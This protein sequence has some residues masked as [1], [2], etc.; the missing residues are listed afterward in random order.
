MQVHEIISQKTLPLV[1]VSIEKVQTSGF[2]P[3]LHSKRLDMLKNGDRSMAGTADDAKI[4]S[5]IDLAYNK[6]VK[7]YPKVESAGSF[8][9]ID[10]ETNKPFKQE[11]YMV[12]LNL[13]DT[14]SDVKFFTSEKAAK[15]FAKSGGKIGGRIDVGNA[16]GKNAYNNTSLR[17]ALAV[18]DVDFDTGKKGLGL[19]RSGSSKVGKMPEDTKA[20]LIE[21]AEEHTKK[22]RKNYKKSYTK[23]Q[24]RYYRKLVHY[25]QNGKML[26]SIRTVGVL[27]AIVV[28]FDEFYEGLSKAIGTAIDNDEDITAAI[29]RYIKQMLP[30]M[31]GDIAAFWGA[32][33]IGG[34]AVRA[35]VRGLLTAFRPFFV[36]LG[37]PAGVAFSVLATIAG[38]VGLWVLLSTDFGQKYLMGMTRG[39]TDIAISTLMND[40]S[41]LT[42]GYTS[43]NEFQ[44]YTS[45]VIN[46]TISEEPIEASK[47]EL[48]A[49]AKELDKENG[50]EKTYSI[51]DLDFN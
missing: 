39:I 1:E 40:V 7:F 37:G 10:R 14:P 25:L 46:S 9:F 3:L 36:L 22:V 30:K 17:G 49:K 31:I 43:S 23:E 18:H 42:E 21:K 41:F 45:K 50:K 20:Q 16:I 19:D 13:T 48:E 33:V 8:E 44:A 35:I 11:V 29:I 2:I 4:T 15:D 32:A 5:K 6:N 47:E 12:K 26:R 34:V 51:D 28:V 24:K 38:E 27:G